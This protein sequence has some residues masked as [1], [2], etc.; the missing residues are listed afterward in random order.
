MMTLMAHP[1][2]LPMS[3]PAEPPRSGHHVDIPMA[4]EAALSTLES[5]SCYASTRTILVSHAIAQKGAVWKAS[6]VG[7]T[8]EVEAALFAGGSTEEI[9]MV[10][11]ARAFCHLRLRDAVA[12]LT[13]LL[14]QD[15][16]SPLSIAAQRGHVRVVRQLI[17][18]GADIETKTTVNIERDRGI[19]FYT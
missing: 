13:C 8:R 7:S 2:E 9:D 12:C 16:K 1:A 11:A 5:Y 18:A 4:E 3:G 19:F 6:E 15:G 17:D 14:A 10:S